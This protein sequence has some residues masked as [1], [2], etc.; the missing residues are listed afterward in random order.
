MAAIIVMTGMQEGDYYALGRETKI[1]GRS[2]DAPVHILDVRISRRH[3][4]I[5]F[6]E[7]KQEYVAID[8]GSQNGVFINDKRISESAALADGDCITIGQT[9]LLFT[10][11]DIADREDALYVLKMGK[12]QCPTIDVNVNTLQDL[13]GSAT[14]GGANRLRSLRQWAGS[15]KTTLAIVFTDI[16]DSTTLTHNLGNERMDQVRRAHFARA[17]SLIE[18]HNGYEI[19]TNGDEFMVAFRTAVN[20]LDFAL[21]LHADAGD[22]RVGI[23]AGVHIGPVI[24]EEEDVQGAAVSYAAR[25]ISAATDGRVWLSSDVRNHIDQEKAQHHDDLCWRSSDGGVLKGFPGK[26]VLWS[27]ER[28]A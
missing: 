13:D 20:A 17:R 2:E 6:D 23:R 5:C 10:M 22:E 11:E 27:V 28:N 19:K 9:H 4:K 8:M 26:H 16:V 7:D 24:I 1:I 3:M 18:E 21:E 25:V 12:L 14:Y 15:A